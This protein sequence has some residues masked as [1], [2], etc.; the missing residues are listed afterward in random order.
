MTTSYAV[1]ALLMSTI[2]QIP[3]QPDHT[4]YFVHRVTFVGSMDKVTDRALRKA[5]TWIEEGKIYRPEALDKTIRAINGLGVFR[6]LNRA[7]CTV[8]RASSFPGT[9]NIEIR[10]NPKTPRD[11]KAA[12]P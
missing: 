5:S 12:N 11:G 1:L 8:T 2:L 4:Q 7:D 3:S 9:V 10:L 6:K